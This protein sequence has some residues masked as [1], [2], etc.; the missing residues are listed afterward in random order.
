MKSQ[1]EKKLKHYTMF[2]PVIIAARVWKQA[3]MSTVLSGKAQTL[4][5]RREKDPP[6]D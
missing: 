6:E 5:E 2:G 3:D 4:V 1:D